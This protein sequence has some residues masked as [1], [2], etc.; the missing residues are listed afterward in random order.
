MPQVLKSTVV[1]LGA[2]FLVSAAF[3]L[4]NEFT[5]SEELSSEKYV[6]VCTATKP[7]N[8]EVIMHTL[9]DRYRAIF[10]KEHDTNLWCGPLS[11][12]DIVPFRTARFKAGLP[13]GSM[14][15]IF[16]YGYR[17]ALGGAAVIDE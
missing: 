2:V 15:W 4:V 5:D 10:L 6:L 16:S 11:M 13:D 17:D 9:P 3:V 12:R 7:R 8:A 1:L 14:V